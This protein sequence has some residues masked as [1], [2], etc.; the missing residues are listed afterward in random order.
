LATEDLETGGPNPDRHP[1]VQLAAVAVE[2][3]T[4]AE[5][6]SIEIKVFFDAR[7][8]NK[9][10]LGKSR[11]LALCGNAKR[12]PNKKRLDGSRRF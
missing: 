12:C 4:L 8:A 10:S 3:A 1:I 11:T 7:K 6:E 9:S 5:V 2:Q